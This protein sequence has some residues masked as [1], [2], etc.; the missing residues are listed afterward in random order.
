MKLRFNF[1]NGYNS[2]ITKA[3]E[4]DEFDQWVNTKFGNRIRDLISDDFTLEIA[5]AFFTADFT[6]ED[7]GYAFLKNFGGREIG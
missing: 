2:E 6:Y 5:E 3:R 4:N 1:P 7:D